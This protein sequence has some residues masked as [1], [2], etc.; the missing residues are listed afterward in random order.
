MKK[1]I[2]KPPY[3]SHYLVLSDLL[4]GADVRA[5]SDVVHYLTSRIEN[6]KT[7]L[8]N[9]YG[10]QFIDGV[11][12]DSTYSYYKPYILEP[13]PENINKAKE[14][15]KKFSTNEVL[16]FLEQK[17]NAEDYRESRGSN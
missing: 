14:L 16:V 6:L 17:P 7:E 12:K 13:T 15:L 4:S 2:K 5:K 8:Q 11:T 1:R 10:L 9:T 3:V